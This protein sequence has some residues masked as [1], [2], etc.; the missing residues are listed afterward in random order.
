MHAAVNR[1][2]ADKCKLNVVNYTTIA[3]AHVEFGNPADAFEVFAE[4]R[5][6]S[7]GP[8]NPT[9]RVAL[10]AVQRLTRRK[11]AIYKS[12]D[13]LS[14]ARVENKSPLCTRTWNLFLKELTKL[15]AVNDA[16]SILTDM[17]LNRVNVPPADVWSFNT[18]IIALARKHKL[19]RALDLFAIMLCGPHPVSPDVVTYNSL[20]E[21]AVLHTGVLPA[22][23]VPDAEER[24]FTAFVNSMNTHAVVP[25]VHTD[26][27]FLRLLCRKGATPNVGAVESIVKKR[28]PNFDLYASSVAQ[29]NAN[30]RDYR[31]RTK[32]DKMFFDAALTAYG[33]AGDM[34]SVGKLLRVMSG[35][36]GPDILTLRAVLTGA[37][38]QGDIA[39]AR[40]ALCIARMHGVQCDQYMYTSAIA[41]CARSK[42]PR[43]D[44]AD[45]LLT[46]AV[47]NGVPWC[48][49]MINAAISAYGDDIMRAVNLWRSLR[50]S[51]TDK[52]VQDLLSER[53]VYDALFRVCGRSIR[54]DLALRV[55]YAAK[56]AHHMN[57]NSDESR[58]VYSAFM[59]GVH[60]AEG[61]DLLHTHLL[62][63]TYFRLL[64]TECGPRD[65]ISWPI[66]RIRIKL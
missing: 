65:S 43:P 7:L 44:T 22:G 50:S 35:V 8:N 34:D 5:R 23:S 15:D 9:I 12:L 4:M 29:K 48:P 62:K 66:E 49:P 46:E 6:Q 56:N 64:R 11:D 37:G 38:H 3:N 27:L 57:P 40:R 32:P 13:V 28:I 31:A 20:L 21:A 1:A 17:R 25:D 47:R 59:K 54:P 52:S 39:F 45:E 41:A 26:T 51:T 60:E 18:C 53:M 16:I 55:W 36:V 19:Y 24:L 33:Q 61:E 2:R 42:P 63:R 14:W 58:I 30:G 10:K